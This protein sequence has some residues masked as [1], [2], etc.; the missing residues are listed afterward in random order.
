MAA[1]SAP[2]P[3]AAPAPRP[4]PREV[5][6]PL[7]RL[8]APYTLGED[9]FSLPPGA[10][11][12]IL[13]C[14]KPADT[15]ELR[16][17]SRDA[18]AHVAGHRWDDTSTPV[19]DL[20][21]WR[22]SF[23]RAVGVKV[24]PAV[25]W[26]PANLALLDRLQILDA[27][28][29]GE[30]AFSSEAL[31]VLGRIP[32]L[33]LRGSPLG[34]L[35]RVVT[36]EGVPAS[37]VEAAYTALPEATEDDVDEEDGGA[38]WDD[39]DALVVALRGAGGNPRLAK[40]LCGALA[41]IAASGERGRRLV[42]WSEGSMAAIAGALAAT[43]ADVAGAAAQTVVALCTGAANVELVSFVLDVLGWE[44][45]TAALTAHADSPAVA[46]GACA[47]IAGLAR[48]YQA[49]G[50]E[51]G[52]PNLAD[53]RAAVR[54]AARA[55]PDD[56]AVAAAALKAIGGLCWFWSEAEE[57]VETN[58]G[59]VV[60]AM[61][62]FL[63]SP[64]V[65]AAGCKALAGLVRYDSERSLE[66]KEGGGYAAVLSALRRHVTDAAVCAA[67][68][69]ATERFCDQYDS[70][71]GA[72]I[73]GVLDAGGA[74]VVVS[75]LR[76]HVASEKVCEAA[77]RALGS[78]AHERSCHQRLVDAGIVPPLLQVLRA[79]KSM[80]GAVCALLKEL[81][82]GSAG[83]ASAI[84]QAGGYGALMEAAAAHR[85]RNHWR[86]LEALAG[87]S[88]NAAV[89]LVAAGGR[90]AAMAELQ[91]TSNQTG[92]LASLV[93]SL[94]EQRQ[95]IVDAG[96]IEAVVTGLRNSNQQYSSDAGLRLLDALTRVSD[97]ALQRGLDAGALQVVLPTLRGDFYG[98]DKDT[99]ITWLKRLLRLSVMRD[100]V[101]AA[102]A[103]SAL[104]DAS[105]G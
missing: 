25:A 60:E 76:Q 62:R 10:L 88:R 42:A 85:T 47:A 56:A 35:M 1:V 59:L 87:A 26:I 98:M 94:P 27:G 100:D 80:N 50:I 73:Q 16:L 96:G 66:I 41:S 105:W 32:R 18:E 102:L 63:N 23:P 95:A 43:S 74:E 89:A 39:M 20:A 82:T 69:E 91:T 97:A 58:L 3:P 6:Q 68:C 104:L 78:L 11:A 84:L 22:A 21:R 61:A 17:V 53:I 81:A 46:A 24:H 31:A 103:A 30:W 36:L 101:R 34:A 65:A 19:V 2:A 54:A 57:P 48:C 55:F 72:C 92:F 44:P 70:W 13:A 67:G 52:P 4:W 5:T 45:V 83:R 8:A 40:A 37:V 33:V 71:P 49:L 79:H 14:L 29:C 93:K 64:A 12:S 7:P 38:G 28:R 90:D 99:R 75:L 15:A 86:V 51:D 77:C 9:V